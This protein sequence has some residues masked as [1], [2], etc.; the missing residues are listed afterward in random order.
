[1]WLS[2]SG[3]K[4]CMT[5]WLSTSGPKIL[6]YLFDTDARF[7][8]TDWRRISKKLIVK[9]YYSLVYIIVKKVYIYNIIYIL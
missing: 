8:K 9:K 5:I 4:S 2:T 6:V 1:M 7:L 3:P